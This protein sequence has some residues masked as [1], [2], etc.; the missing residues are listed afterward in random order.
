VALNV[1][2]FLPRPPEIVEKKDVDLHERSPPR[3]DP[4]ELKPQL[5]GIKLRKLERVMR[6][7]D[8]NGFA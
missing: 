5:V 8:L 7:P 4:E 2:Q 1:V 3:V 6:G